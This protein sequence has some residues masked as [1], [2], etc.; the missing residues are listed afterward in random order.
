MPRASNCTRLRLI[1]SRDR[2]D[3]TWNEKRGLRRGYFGLTCSSASADNAHN[4]R[5]LRS[6]RRKTP[7]FWAVCSVLYIR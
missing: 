2:A 3:P 5:V 7:C 6:A 1:S 4:P